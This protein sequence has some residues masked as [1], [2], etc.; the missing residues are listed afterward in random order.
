MIELINKVKLIFRAYEISQ[1]VMPMDT[2]VTAQDEKTT[3]GE[4]IEPVETL[5]NLLNKNENS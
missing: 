4:Y 2:S 5:K 1:K 3:N